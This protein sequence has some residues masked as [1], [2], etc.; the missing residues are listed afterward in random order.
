M[1]QFE[2]A[3]VFSCID[4]ADQTLKSLEALDND[5]LHQLTNWL[6]NGISDSGDVG[7][8]QPG[9]AAEIRKLGNYLSHRYENETGVRAAQFRR[10]SRK[11]K[12]SL[13]NSDIDAN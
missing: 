8:I 2:P 11:L 4:R 9:M 7:I 6:D 3:A 10:L 5:R 1:A 13:L 12:D